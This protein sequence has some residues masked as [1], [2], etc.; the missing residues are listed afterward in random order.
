MSRDSG[1]DWLIS[2]KFS[3]P[4]ADG[5]AVATDGGGKGIDSMI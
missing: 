5:A 1:R 4:T 2:C 3:P